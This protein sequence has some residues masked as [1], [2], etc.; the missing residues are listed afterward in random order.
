MPMSTPKKKPQRT[1]A[2]SA[3]KTA[4]K[5]QDASS[6]RGPEKYGSAY[7]YVPR[8]DTPA[9]FRLY[10]FIAA[11]RGSEEVAYIPVD[12]FMAGLFLRNSLPEADI[13][14]ASVVEA[15][16]T[17]PLNRMVRQIC[18]SLIAEQQDNQ[19]AD[20]ADFSGGGMI[21]AFGPSILTTEKDPAAE[22]AYAEDQEDEDNDA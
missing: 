5:E 2:S 8:S 18:D 17:T 7:G 4:S 1:A 19:V 3:K 11:T 9:D 21:P 14:F 10:G 16:L 6:L 22:E 13:R 15:V 20:D 12:M